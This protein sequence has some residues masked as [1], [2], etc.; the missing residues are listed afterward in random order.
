[1]GMFVLLLGLFVWSEESLVAHAF[2]RSPLAAALQGAVQNA[3]R[4]P[5]LSDVASL[6]FAEQ[7]RIVVRDD[8]QFA[9]KRLIEC[10]VMTS[11]PETNV[12]WFVNKQLVHSVAQRDITLEGNPEQTI[13]GVSQTRHRFCL[14]PFLKPNQEN[15]VSC[16][17]QSS[18]KSDVIIES[19][20][21]VTMGPSHNSPLTKYSPQAPL[22][23]LVTATRM[24]IA[25]QF[26][27]L[28]CHA[29]GKPKPNIEWMVLDDADESKVYP[30]SDFKDFIYVLDGGD[31]LINTAA[32]DRASI[33]LQCNAS[34]ED[35]YDAAES[36]LIILAPN[37]SQ[38]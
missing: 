26:V 36:S 7:P 30:I 13:L 4:C 16:R 28:F 11:P 2:P 25:G 24:E 23:T 38:S 15:T 17:V 9:C 6:S 32:T 1:M 5:P 27:Q 34:N 33:T 12:Y 20:P 18:C 10:D 29:T 3:R 14:D 21:L 8:E 31:V 35:G 22:I 37:D 19:P